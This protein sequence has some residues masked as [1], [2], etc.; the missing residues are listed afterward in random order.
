MIATQHNPVFPYLLIFRCFLQKFL[1]Y[2]TVARTIHITEIKTNPVSI[3]QNT[4]EKRRK[5]GIIPARI[6]PMSPILYNV[7]N[8]KFLF[9]NM[10]IDLLHIFGQA[11]IC[12][13]IQM[14]TKPVTGHIYGFGC[15]VYNGCDFFG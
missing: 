9:I 10:L 2:N 13:Q 11:V 5:K 12:F 1:T 3:Y 15:R 4:I 7:F 8:F 6:I 14:F